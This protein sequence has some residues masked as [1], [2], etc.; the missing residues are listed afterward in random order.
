MNDLQ[1]HFLNESIN[2]L[3]ALS[4]DLSNNFS[5]N[6]RREAFRA[7]HTI[8]G[9]A[10]TFGLG[11]SARIAHDLE[12]ILAEKNIEKTNDKTGEL[13]IRNIEK[14]IASLERE[15][16]ECAALFDSK[17]ERENISPEKNFTFADA[18][19]LENFSEKEK[20]VLFAALSAKKSVFCAEVGFDVSQFA[21]GYK[22]FREIL[23]QN[24][25]VIAAFPHEKL[26]TGGKI[27]FKIYFASFEAE[28]F[29]QN[30][31]KD[32]SATISLAAAFTNLGV[33]IGDVLSKAIEHGEKTAEL[34]KKRI[35]FSVAA[36]DFSASPARMKTIFDALL[37]L[38]RNAVDH[39][40][41]RRGKIRIGAKIS[42][43]GIVL[44]VSDDGKGI[45]IE[46]VRRAAKDKNLSINLENPSREE[47]LNLIFEPEFSTAEKV[48]EISGRGVGLDAV[49]NLVENAGGR[50]GVK[51]E[52]GKG[53]TFEIFLPTYFESSEKTEHDERERKDKKERK[54]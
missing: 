8:K 3:K 39:G 23:D 12:Q 34:L 13:L 22:K 44:I 4:E 48:G 54:L 35:E 38:I 32:F 27:G 52:K 30:Q 36:D 10:Q 40:I 1:K 6:L 29:L 37:H 41:E 14:L 17:D 26:S 45:D 11:G 18:D 43:N 47:V 7:F 46:K 5:E 9:T 24:G 33:R 49:K 2:K 31:A 20:S 21:A 50:I 19:F 25:E 16:P 42:E 51:S 28:D 15:N 53:T